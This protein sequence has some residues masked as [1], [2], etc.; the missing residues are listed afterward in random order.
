[1]R[2]NQQTLGTHSR[3]HFLVNKRMSKARNKK[4]KLDKPTES[5]ATQRRNRV[6]RAK[7]QVWLGAQAAFAF[8]LLGW[9]LAALR[10]GRWS[11]TKDVA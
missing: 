11:S 10:D 3:R 5:A 8:V 9:L 1:M 6:A 2:L 4:A 7:Q